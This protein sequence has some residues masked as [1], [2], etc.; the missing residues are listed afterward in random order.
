MTEQEETYKFLKE[1][2]SASVPNNRKEI[3]LS[4]IKLIMITQWRFLRHRRMSTRR[5][6]GSFH[7]RLRRGSRR[8]RRCRCRRRDKRR[9]RFTRTHLRP[10]SSPKLGCLRRRNR[11]RFR[12][13]WCR[14]FVPV[15]K[16][17]SS[18]LHLL[19][20]PKAMP[21]R[22]NPSEQLTLMPVET[23]ITH[24]N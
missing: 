17:T 1:S 10:R 13:Q 5:R 18:H 16:F 15:E 4:Q 14:V 23:F 6:T 9:G 24:L 8:K 7:R 2:L 22:V 11:G 19:L 20:S 3:N 21:T 12:R